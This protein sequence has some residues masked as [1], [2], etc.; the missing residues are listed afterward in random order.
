M[1]TVLIILS[2]IIGMGCIGIVCWSI[3]IDETLNIVNI[4]ME[5]NEVKIRFER[6]RFRII[7]KKI[8]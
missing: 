7:Y 6:D 5:V 2:T 1:K 8:T 4:V 3:A